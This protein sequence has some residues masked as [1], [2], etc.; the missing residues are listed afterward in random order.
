MPTLSLAMIVRNEEAFLAHSLASVRDLVDELI[1]VDTGSTDRSPEIAASFGARVHSHPWADDFSAARN[2]SLR[3]CTGDWVL[4]LD[5]D[6][7]IDPLD[8]PQIR[9][10]L[11]APNPVPRLL[12]VRNYFSDPAMATLDQAALPNVDSPYAEGRGFP[13]YADGSVLRLFPRLPGVAYAG[14]IHESVGPFFSARGLRPRDCPAVIHHYGKTAAPRETSKKAYYL[15]LAR[16]DAEA[17][18]QEPQVL[19]NLALQAFVAQ[20]WQLALDSARAYRTRVP[21]PLPMI[22]LILGSA[23]LALGHPREAL[24]PLEELLHQHPDHVLGRVQLALAQARLG[25]AEA[26]RRAFARALKAD[27]G[28]VPVIL[29]WAGYEREAGAPQ[30]AR[31]LLLRGL[32]RLPRSPELNQALIQLSL[33]T[34]PRAQAVADAWGAIQRLPEGGQGHWH[35]LVAFALLEQGQLRPAR[36]VVDLGLGPFPQH[37]A[38]QELR[39]RLEGKA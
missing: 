26:A 28:S 21:R 23:L 30:E 1:V 8:H 16:R 18:P 2:E 12:V 6:E 29:A 20:E 17:R 9:Q 5:A 33:E 36:T 25:H 10:I 27:P 39:K 7:A 11:E 15:E 3:H 13:Y 37:A 19:Y 4:V 34:A 35:H 22:P 38:L 24:P 14:L 32:E 31:T